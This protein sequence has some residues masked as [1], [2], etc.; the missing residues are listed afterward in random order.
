M[1]PQSLIFARDQD[2]L[3]K[4]KKEKR[5][6]KKGKRKKK[7]EK[8]KKNKCLRA[9]FYAVYPLL[10]RAVPSKFTKAYE[11]HKKAFGEV[12]AMI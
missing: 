2:L 9:T 6:K 7:K 8:R 12:F 11:C 5:K 1:G 3:K 4:K 10:A